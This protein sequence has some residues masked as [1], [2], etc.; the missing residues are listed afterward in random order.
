MENNEEMEVT[1]EISIEEEMDG[2]GIR[3]SKCLVYF[4]VDLSVCL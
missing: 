2:G 3:Q 1:K 4:Y